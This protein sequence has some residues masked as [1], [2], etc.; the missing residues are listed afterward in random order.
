VSIIE[1]AV[2]KGAQK[3]LMPVTVRKQLFDLPDDLATKVAVVYYTDAR[4]ALLK[5]LSE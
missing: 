2:D 5:A 4:D 1:L 3:I